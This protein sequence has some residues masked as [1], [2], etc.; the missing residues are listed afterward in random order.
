MDDSLPT[1]LDIF[2]RDPAFPRTSLILRCGYDDGLYTVGESEQEVELPNGE[3]ILVYAEVAVG[4]SG[5]DISLSI[6][7]GGRD[8][9]VRCSAGLIVSY[10]TEQGLDVLCQIGTG[11]WE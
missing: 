7:Q 3:T 10:T 2:F 4:E 9:D 8:F 11:G 1:T 6:I 5:P